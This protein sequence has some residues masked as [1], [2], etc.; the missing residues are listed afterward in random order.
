MSTVTSRDAL[1]D[2]ERSLAA[3]RAARGT[4]AER[5]FDR[6][7]PADRDHLAR[8]LRELQN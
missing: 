8:I 1:D 7:S 5:G 2:L 3:I 6:L 4:E